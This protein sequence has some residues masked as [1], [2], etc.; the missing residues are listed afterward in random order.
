MRKKKKTR[1]N[2]GFIVKNLLPKR[3]QTD[4][5]PFSFLSLLIP[6]FLSAFSMCAQTPLV[7]FPIKLQ[8]IKSDKWITI[9]LEEWSDDNNK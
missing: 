6:A 9:F 8:I 7:D 4:Q 3:K 2:I 1:E 5:F